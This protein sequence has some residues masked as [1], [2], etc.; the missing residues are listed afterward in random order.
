MAGLNAEKAREIVSAVAQGREYFSAAAE[1]GLLVRPLLQYYGVLSLSRALILL[2]SRSLRETSLPQSHGIG[3]VKWS[4]ALVNDARRPQD[5]EVTV[6]NGTFLSL[7]ESTRNSDLSGA[8]TGPYP[9]RLIFPRPRNATELAGKTF[10]FQQ[11]LARISELRDVYE[12][13]FGQAS[14]NYRAFIFMLSATI[15]TDIDIF[16]GRHDLPPEEQI[17][18]ELSIAPDVAIRTVAN[19]NFVAQELHYNYRL[20]HGEG[21]HFLEVLPQIE[22]GSDGYENV[23]CPF[24][25]GISIS[26]LGRYFLMSFY[27]GTL[28]RYHPTSWLAIMQGRQKGDLM[29]PLIR[30]AMSVLQNNF[31]AFIIREL[32]W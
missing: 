8:F 3:S 19:H 30:E 24:E 23:I 12:R 16:P 4:Q 11:V 14:A 22:S 29:L 28:A 9:N 31:P 5:L 20:I 26:R 18:R 21:T 6:T 10:T 2:L 1:G 15:Q 17:R 27:L 13:S 7:L 25:P 32:E